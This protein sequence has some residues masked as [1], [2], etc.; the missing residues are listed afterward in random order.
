[1]VS[2]SDI[3]EELQNASKLLDSGQADKVLPRLTECLHRLNRG[4]LGAEQASAALLYYMSAAARALDRSTLAEGYARQSVSLIRDTTEFSTDSA[5]SAVVLLVLSDAL[6]HRGFPDEAM[7]FADVALESLSHDLF[8]IPHDEIA[9]ILRRYAL[10]AAEVGL[11]PTAQFAFTL[12]LIVL[13]SLNGIESKIATDAMSIG[14]SFG[15]GAIGKV[16]SMLIRN[17]KAAA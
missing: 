16:G 11:I 6:L 12:G 3:S 1:M 15:F 2:L 10:V 14:K 4:S 7:H 9:E 13:Q 5:K 17:M 8:L